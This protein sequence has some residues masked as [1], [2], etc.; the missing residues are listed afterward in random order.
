MQTPWRLR[1]C[2][3]KSIW[4]HAD[5]LLQLLE[6]NPNGLGANYE[7]LKMPLYNLKVDAMALDLSDSSSNEEIVFSTPVPS[8]SVSPLL[9]PRPVLVRQRATECAYPSATM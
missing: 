1:R 9:L 4:T 2:L 8:P 7:S 3:I 5:I 6:L